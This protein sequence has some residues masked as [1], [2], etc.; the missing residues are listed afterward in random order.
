MYQ[1]W[2]RNAGSGTAGGSLL[3]GTE[4]NFSRLLLYLRSGGGILTKVFPTPFG[5]RL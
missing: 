3:L 4:I 5:E 1:E 2:R